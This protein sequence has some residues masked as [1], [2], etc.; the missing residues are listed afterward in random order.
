MGAAS[1][2]CFPSP[3]RR[4]LCGG[5]SRRGALGRSS[6]S[7][8][9]RGW[10]PSCSAAPSSLPRRFLHCRVQAPVSLRHLA[11]LSDQRCRT[12]SA[13]AR[14]WLCDPASR[15]ASRGG[16]RTR[17]C[18][19]DWR[20]SPPWTLRPSSGTARAAVWRGV[21]AEKSLP[22]GRHC[23]DG[24]A[25]SRSIGHEGPPRT[26]RRC[27]VRRPPPSRAHRRPAPRRRLCFSTRTSTA[28]RSTCRRFSG[29]RRA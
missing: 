12:S 26:A 19:P 5:C 14:V 22:Q 3:P 6:P 28:S 9:C 24:C 25:R 4:P 18:G 8:S 2:L 15:E 7:L 17:P 1:A 29:T 13:R 11:T 10:R 21:A 20:R 23:W 16:S 27:G